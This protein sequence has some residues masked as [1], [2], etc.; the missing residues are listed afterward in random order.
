MYHKSYRYLVILLCRSLIISGVHDLILRTAVVTVNGDA[1]VE[2]SVKYF[3]FFLYYWPARL[4][5]IR[6]ITI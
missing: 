3:F 5:L 2:D 6:M 4:L 1:P